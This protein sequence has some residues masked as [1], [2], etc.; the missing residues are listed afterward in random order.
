MKDWGEGG[1]FVPPLPFGTAAAAAPH[2]PPHPFPPTPSPPL[3][4]TPP[5]GGGREERGGRGGGGEGG[6]G[7]GEGEEVG[8]KAVVHFFLVSYSTL[9]TY[10][11]KGGWGGGRHIFLKKKK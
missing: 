3:P 2:P 6:G 11:Y 10:L 8:D 4:P 1:D 7:E 5:K 9:F